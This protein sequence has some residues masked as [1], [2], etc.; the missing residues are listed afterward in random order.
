M[1]TTQIAPFR[2]LRWF[3]GL[4]A[5]VIVLIAWA[6]A[7]VVS[8][9]LADHLF[10]REAAVSRDFVQNVLVSDGSINYL[11]HPDDPEL[12]RSFHNSIA[13]LSNMHD[14]LR[15]NV[16]GRDKL[17]L[18]STDKSL[19]GQ[20]FDDNAELV[21]ALQ[22]ELVVH[23]GRITSEER[24][25][26]EYAG[27]SPLA[28]FLRPNILPSGLGFSSMTCS[29]VFRSNSAQRA[30][31]SSRGAWNFRKRSPTAGTM[32]SLSTAFLNMPR[33]S[34]CAALDV[35]SMRRVSLRA[36]SAASS[37]FSRSRRALAAFR[38][39]ISSSNVIRVSSLL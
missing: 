38:A 16:Y 3:A 14:V 15:A 11:A 35:D 24:P 31:S 18:W 25:K 1:P 6:N 34:A 36:N 39:A 10:Q 4:S 29:M 2:L 17:M 30:W 37:D 5:V 12:Q 27:L 19:S 8:N 20:R 7:W 26:S 22:G 21:E 23:S 28:A 33:A 32:S 13:H 9:F